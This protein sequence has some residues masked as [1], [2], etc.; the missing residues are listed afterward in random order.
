LEESAFLSFDHS[1]QAKSIV[2]AISKS[3]FGWSNLLIL[4]GLSKVLRPA[5]GA[6][7]KYPH[8]AR[9][10][11]KQ[12][13]NPIKSPSAQSSLQKAPPKKLEALD[14]ARTVA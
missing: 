9:I 11:F 5:I 1:R 6:G 3:P 7:R 13:K 10:L 8:K 2:Q 14:L 12:M 4:N